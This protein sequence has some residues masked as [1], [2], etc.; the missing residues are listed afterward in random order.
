MIFRELN[1]SNYKKLIFKFS[2]ILL[3][4]FKP[5]VGL[6]QKLPA[7][8]PTVKYQINQAGPNQEPLNVSAIVIPE[9]FEEAFVE[10]LIKDQ[11]RIQNSEVISVE[12]QL[13]LIQSVKSQK[14]YKMMIKPSS[15]NITVLTANPSFAVNPQ[16]KK[17]DRLPSSEVSG[18]KSA[19]IYVALTSITGYAI[20]FYI[21]HDI[22]PATA[23]T[24]VSGALF[25][26]MSVKPQLLWGYLNGGGRLA[27]RYLGKNV[28]KNIK[29]VIH[30]SGKAAAGVLFNVLLTTAFTVS[31]SYPTLLER[32]PSFYHFSEYIIPTAIA[33][34][35]SKN[36]WD[37][38]ISKWKINES[39]PVSD[40]TALLLNYSKILFIAAIAPL[41]YVQSTRT[42]AMIT[43]G[44][45][46][47][48][49]IPGFYYEEKYRQTIERLIEKI[50]NSNSVR[51]IV[52]FS[53]NSKN[54]VHDLKN[55]L[56]NKIHV[57]RQHR[58]LRLFN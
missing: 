26:L 10:G 49:A 33:S 40:K 6:T 57:G 56:F 28:N 2:L 13:V 35:G 25:Y 3:I 22:G 36:M 48:L 23:G 34:F 54:I 9:S 12:R 50:E 11:K 44:F 42:G 39:N 18:P 7:F 43:L 46:G 51:L 27:T 52:S 17:F 32:F 53:Q 16:N 55:G 37:M 45:F 31:L 58:C 29:A 8:L 4:F 47:A 30:E 21:T 38:V 14:N 41:M 1:D 24:I 5:L 20:S 19:G 15:P